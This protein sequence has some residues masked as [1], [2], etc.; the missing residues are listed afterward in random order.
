MKAILYGGA[1]DPVH[2]GHLFIGREALRILAP[3]R[4]ILIPTG[5][6]NP[7]FDKSICASAA[8]RKAMLQLAFAGVEH[9]EICDMELKKTGAPSYFVETLT[10]LLPLVGPERPILL[11]GEDQL[12]SFRRWY[13]YEEILQK[14]DLW[15][16]P[17][18]QEHRP[19]QQAIPARVLFAVN[20][21]DSLSST[22]VRDRAQAGLS[23]SELVPA[24]VAGYIEQR[25][26]YRKC[27]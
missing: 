10:A 26:L 4:L 11:I 24:A 2:V 8:D 23:I 25:H 21:F 20:P 19:E 17:R 27:P 5:V 15:F 9:V 18:A 1:F 22:L 14:V 3:A 16:V 7:G 13:R 12:L 6:P